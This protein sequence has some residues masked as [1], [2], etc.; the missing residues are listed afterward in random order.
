MNLELLLLVPLL[1]PLPLK[2]QWAMRR[3]L[4]FRSPDLP[5]RILAPIKGDCRHK[6]ANITPAD[7]F[8]IENVA[9]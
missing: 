9:A 4:V 8:I 6:H 5:E 3:K 2:Y 1:L 7:S